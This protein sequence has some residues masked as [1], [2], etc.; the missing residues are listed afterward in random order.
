MHTVPYSVPIAIDQELASSYEASIALGLSFCSTPSIVFTSLLR[1]TIVDCPRPIYLPELRDPDQESARAHGIIKVVLIP[2][3]TYH[4]I[5]S[6]Y[7]CLK[8]VVD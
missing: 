3:G 2:Q 6:L 7:S 8:F 1:V 5:I 4:S